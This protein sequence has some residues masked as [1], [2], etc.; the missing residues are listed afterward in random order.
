MD[1]SLISKEVAQTNTLVQQSTGPSTSHDDFALARLG[2]RPVLKRNFGFLAILGFS[3]TVLITWEGSLIG[4]ISGLQN[5]GPSGIIYGFLVVWVGTLSVFGTLSELVSMAPTSGGQYH[6][7]SMLAPP[8]SRKFFGYI[9]GWLEVTG[10]QSLVASGGYVTG[11]MIQ[12]IILLTYP[13]Y[14]DHMQNWHGTLLFWGIV[15]LSY[16]INTAVGSLLAKFEGIFLVIHLLGFF[17]V[18][19]PLALLSQH[20]DSASVFDTFLNPGGWQTQGLSFCIGVLGNVFAFLGGDA[21]I[22]MSEEIRNAAVVIPRSL[23]TG[24]LVNGTLGFGMLIATLYCMGDIDQALA[25]N[26]HYPFMSIFKAATGST[27]GAAVMSAIVVVMA[28]SATTGSLASTSRVYFAFARDRGLPGWR[29]LKKVSPRTSIPIYSVITT[30]VI[31][32][33]LSL[34]NIGDSTAFNGVIS[35][36]TAG[37]FGSYLIAA[38]LLLYRRVT[39]GIRIANDDDVLTNTVGSSLTWG[40]WRLHGIFGVVNNIFSCIYLVFIFFFSFWPPALEVTPQTMNYA[41]LVF[42]TVIMFSML[43]YAVW[44][45]KVYS[46]P[47]IESIPSAG[48]PSPPF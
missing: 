32:V 23:L 34:V 40:P 5:G 42:G 2:K 28:F 14:A 13:G 19:L 35:I 4:F 25:E 22:H 1:L 47:I 37:L 31:A 44:A 39:G 11:T 3:C 36:S 48:S 20:S 9:T 18:I 6:W 43:Y 38:S 26:P 8:S 17:A 46:G 10:W 41:V 30:A 33:I 29:T 21:A 45:R 16:G 24:L 27:A 7:V 15:L 12:G